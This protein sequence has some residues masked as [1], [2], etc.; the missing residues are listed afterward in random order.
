MYLSLYFYEFKNLIF[1]GL[2]LYV[3]MFGRFL[4]RNILEPRNWLMS[5]LDELVAA[6]L[7]SESKRNDYIKLLINAF[8]KEKL[9]ADESSTECTLKS[10]ELTE[11]KTNL[12]LF[13]LAGYE[14]TSTALSYC[15][16]IL[17]KHPEEQQKLVDEITDYLS[18]DNS[19]KI[20]TDNVHELTYLELFAKEVLRMYPIANPVMTRRCTVATTVCDIPLPVDSVVAVDVLTIHNDPEIWGP[21]DPSEFYPLR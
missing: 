7:S 21:V 17:A 4:T 20:N 10:Q 8:M 9:S 12:I 11:I 13:M 5:K 3:N 18:E 15:V 19:R 6:R 14:T 1:N 2:N 16:Y